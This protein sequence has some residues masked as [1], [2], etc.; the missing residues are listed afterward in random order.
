VSEATPLAWYWLFSWTT[1]LLD[2]YQRGTRPYLG[3]VPTNPL[4]P[5]CGVNHGN[6]RL[7]SIHFVQSRNC[8]NLLSSLFIYLQKGLPKK[9]W[10]LAKA[11]EKWLEALKNL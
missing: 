4:Q 8:D 7:L 11:V 2:W 5:C 3:G 9:C 10:V 6:Q 1:I